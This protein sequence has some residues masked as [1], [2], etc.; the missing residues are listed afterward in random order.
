MYIGADWEVVHSVYLAYTCLFIPNLPST[1]FISMYC[2]VL[3]W[4]IIPRSMRKTCRSSTR[5][6]NVFQ[7]SS[8]TKKMKATPRSCLPASAALLRGLFLKR[9]LP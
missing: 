4:T 7:G 5:S 8:V 6:G 9:A 2:D 1:S 3:K